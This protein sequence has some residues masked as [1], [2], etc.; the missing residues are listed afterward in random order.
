M[1]ESPGGRDLTLP[2]G[3][4]GGPS[5]S[6]EAHP[7]PFTVTSKTPA[8]HCPAGSSISPVGAFLFPHGHTTREDESA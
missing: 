8:F 7:V 6:R 1:K 4:A 3:F 5:G 2:S